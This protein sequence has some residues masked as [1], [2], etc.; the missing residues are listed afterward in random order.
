MISSLNDFTDL[1]LV[2]A[3]QLSEAITEIVSL[4]SSSHCRAVNI[5]ISS[6]VYTDNWFVVLFLIATIYFGM[7]TAAPVRPDSFDPSV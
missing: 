2:S 3:A 5:A 4:F 6:T 1:M 7:I